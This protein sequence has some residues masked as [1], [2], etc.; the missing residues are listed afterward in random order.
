V[1]S[2][3]SKIE[4]VQQPAQN[5]LPPP[6]ALR[7]RDIT[8][9]RGPGMRGLREVPNAPSIAPGRITAPAA[10]TAGAGGGSAMAAVAVSPEE[11]AAWAKSTPRNAPCP[12][13]SGKKYKHCHGQLA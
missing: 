10:A 7:D 9:V 8:P 13:G 6:V 3:L 12:C 4:I 11:A 5:E 1:V 2:Q